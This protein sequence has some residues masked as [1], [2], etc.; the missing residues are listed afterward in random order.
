[1]RGTGT[2]PIPPKCGHRKIA[3]T[4]AN[5]A[6]VLR[7]MVV[8][9]LARSTTI[10]SAPGS[11]TLQY[12]VQVDVFQDCPM[13]TERESRPIRSAIT[14]AGIVGYVRSISRTRGSTSSPTNPAPGA[15]TSPGRVLRMVRRQRVRTRLH[16]PEQSP[17]THARCSTRA[18]PASI[19]GSTSRFQ[20]AP[21]R[22]PASDVCR[23][24]RPIGRGRWKWLGNISPG[25]LARRLCLPAVGTLGRSGLNLRSVLAPGAGRAAASPCWP[26][27]P[28]TGI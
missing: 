15:G 2:P 28:V 4:P 26:P 10:A 1:L 7:Q 20:P 18:R 19:R 17:T 11:T 3:A 21:A 23:D 27:S 8:P 9:L 24:N 13:L 6:G 12:A 25:P 5:A 14:V 16:R 22:H